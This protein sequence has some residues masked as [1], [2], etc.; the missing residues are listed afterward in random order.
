MKAENLI[1]SSVAENTVNFSKRLDIKLTILNC[2]CGAYIYMA[3]L[4]IVLCDV[5]V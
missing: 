1:F 3:G 2:R 5:C 4:L